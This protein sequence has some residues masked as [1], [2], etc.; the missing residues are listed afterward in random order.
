MSDKLNQLRVQID[1][2]NDELL[3]I[4]NK[5]AEIVIEIGKA[6]QEIG[7]QVFDPE[8]EELIL[9]SLCSRNNG[10]LTDGMIRTI[11]QQ[12]FDEYSNLQRELISKG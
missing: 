5:R 8:R 1:A 6:K 7:M 9:R 3:T 4:L 2:I 11:F 10:L 12:I